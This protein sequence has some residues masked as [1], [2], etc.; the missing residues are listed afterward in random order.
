MTRSSQH[1]PILL[2]SSHPQL[3]QHIENSRSLKGLP[4]RFVQKKSAH[5]ERSISWLWVEPGHQ[6]QVCITPGR[7]CHGSLPGSL[8]QI[9][10][11]FKRDGSERG[12]VEVAFMVSI[13]RYRKWCT[14]WLQRFHCRGFSAR[15]CGDVSGNDGQT[16]N[17]HGPCFLDWM[18]HIMR[19]VLTLK[20]AGHPCQTKLNR[21]EVNRASE[22]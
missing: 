21:D 17:F 9:V 12:K 16:I 11:C 5:E 15:S 7:G 4:R 2:C 13:G 19:D 1:P 10:D 22:Q 3:V 6:H 18:P 14:H 8:S 20:Y